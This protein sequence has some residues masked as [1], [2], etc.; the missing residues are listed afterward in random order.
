MTNKRKI[1]N[2]PVY[3][4]LTIEDDLIF[5]VLQHPYFQRQR[6]IK[7]LGLTYLVYP[8]AVHNRFSHMLGALN[9]MCRA[10]DVLK[11]KGVQI[12]HDEEL[13]VK[14]FHRTNYAIRLTDE[15]E[16]FLRRAKDI[17]SLVDKTKAE[18]RSEEDPA[19]YEVTLG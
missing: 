17:L 14:L 16:I 1:F 3:G 10:I 18:F 7:Q 12:T 13:G 15:G 2:D 8:G 11:M 6:H 9:L 4:F 19:H 5:D